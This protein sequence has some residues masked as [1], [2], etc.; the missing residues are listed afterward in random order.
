MKNKF[1]NY[2]ILLILIITFILVFKYPKE[3][4]Y[5]V[6]YSINLWKNNIV[7][8]TFTLFV[9]SDLLIEYGLLNLINKILNNKV[10]GNIITIFMLSLLSGFPSSAKYTKKFLEEDKITIEEANYIIMFCNFSNPLF[11][12][13]TIGIN[14]LNNVKYGYIILIS[15]IISNII[16]GIYYKRK[17]TKRKIITKKQ[18]SNKKEFITILTSS[19]N[20]TFKI[21]INILGIITVFMIISLLIEKVLKKN[22]ITMIIKSV[23]EMTQGTLL[24]SK[25]NI[26]YKLKVSL[27]GALISFNGISIHMQIKS[28]LDNTKIKYSNYLK[29]RILQS[30]ICFIIIYIFI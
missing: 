22:I 8:T 26:Y 7:P 9:I 21:L 13:S 23:L 3:I 5:S 20:D 19:I 16:I 6:L 30:I 10:N 14:Y 24:I 17:I 15:H 18:E 1:N 27:I 4:T 25:S 29:G 28:I 11:I 2:S 12:I